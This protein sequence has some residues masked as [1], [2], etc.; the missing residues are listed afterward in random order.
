MATEEVEYTDPVSATAHGPGA[1]AGWV[2]TC[3]RAFPDYRFEES[4]GPYLASDGSKA[5][6]V[7]R[8]LG[9]NTGPL[10]PPGFAP[11]NRSFVLDG[12][13]HWWFRDGLLAR[14]RADYDLNGVLRQL[15]LVPQPGSAAERAMV[16]LQ[17]AAA[18]LRR[19]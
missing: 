11:T 4:E 3:A 14:Y 7:W 18:R 17:R 6:V 8:M 15:G 12:V 19:R 13:D 5:I 1:V 2:R 9:T 10:D 16:T